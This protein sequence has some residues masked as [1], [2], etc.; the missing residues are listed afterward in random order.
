MAAAPPQAPAATA[1]RA[2]SA[3]RAAS[4]SSL[5]GALVA[6]GYGDLPV[7]DIIYLKNTGI[8]GDYLSSFV[9]AWG[10]VP[11]RELAEAR[12]HGLVAEYAGR[13]RAAGLKDLTLRGAIDLR[14]HGVDPE[15][16]RQIHA[17]GFGPY[18]VQDAIELRRYGVSSDLFRGLK[19]SGFTQPELRDVIQAR[20]NG[21]RA[22][23]LREAAKIG[24]S[25]TL[26]QIIRLKQA[27][28]I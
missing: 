15:Q 12:K 2:A 17:L 13:M 16:L 4:Q 25:L 10:K 11:A 22:E 5:L 21:L 24:S 27:G 8:T 20:M 18:T 23:H 3:A 19:E 26:R 1:P 9:K 14:N 7:D 28:V 6:N